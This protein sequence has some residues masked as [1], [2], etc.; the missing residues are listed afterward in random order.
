MAD[1]RT[2]D[3]VLLRNDLESAVLPAHPEIGRLKADLVTSG[4]AGAVM[5]G[6]GSA[7]VGVLVEDT[8]DEAAAVAAGVRARHPQAVVHVARILSPGPM[9]SVDRTTSTA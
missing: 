6:S 3:P 1:R 4:A 8:P 9:R 7:V 5:S 2:L